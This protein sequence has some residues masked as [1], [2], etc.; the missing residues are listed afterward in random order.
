MAERSEE[1]QRKRDEVSH[2]QKQV[3]TCRVSLLRSTFDYELISV[4]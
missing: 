4:H 1:I 3:A 2:L